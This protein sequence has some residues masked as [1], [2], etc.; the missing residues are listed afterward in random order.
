MKDS[1]KWV[2]MDRAMSFIQLNLLDEVLF[3][4]MDEKAAPQLWAEPESFYMMA[5][6]SHRKQRSASM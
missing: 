1:D 5:D 2:N 4:A 3:D 6:S